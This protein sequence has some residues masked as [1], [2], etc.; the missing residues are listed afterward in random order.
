MATINGDSTNNNLVGTEFDDRINGGGG[1]DTLSG[2]D[3]D[4]VIFNGT[5]VFGGD[6][7]DDLSGDVVFGGNDNDTLTGETDVNFLFGDSG[8]DDLRA[9]FGQDNMDGGSGSDTVIYEGSDVGV[10]VFLDGTGS[11]GDAQ[12]D[13]YISI[14]NVIG[15]TFNDTVFGTDLANKILGRDGDD[16]ITVSEMATASELSPYEILTGFKLRLP[17]RYANDEQAVVAA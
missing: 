14:E 12:G 3:G 11:G 15:S 7:F 6:G 13:T 2:L 10:G 5:L 8:D 1:I 4:D 9:G 17:R 16:V